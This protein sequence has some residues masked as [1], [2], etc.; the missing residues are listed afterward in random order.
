MP[1][2][3]GLLF[4]SEPIVPNA[5][6]TTL[7]DVTGCSDWLQITIYIV[8]H[9]IVVCYVLLTAFPREVNPGQFRKK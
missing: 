2:S 6:H 7:Y 4:S 5:Y 3:W 1:T 8:I 9:V